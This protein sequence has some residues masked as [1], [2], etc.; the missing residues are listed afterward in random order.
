MEWTDTETNR[1]HLNNASE[2]V[3]KDNLPQWQIDMH[4][5]LVENND[6]MLMVTGSDPNGFKGVPAERLMFVQK[7]P[8]SALR[9]YPKQ[10][11]QEKFPG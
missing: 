6:C 1:I 10:G 3:L 8:A 2:E 7:T 5:S 4:E 9:K 11:W